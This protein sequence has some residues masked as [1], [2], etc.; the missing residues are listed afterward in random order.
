MSYG[1]VIG[2]SFLYLALLFGLASWAERR[3]AAG[4]SL[5]SNPYIYALSMAV[6]CTAW[7]YYGSIGRA[8]TTGLEFLAIYLG[9]TLMAPLWWLVLR[10]IIRIC[11]VQRITTIADFI[12]SRYGKSITLGSVVTIICV[13]GT[14]PY[15]SIQLKAIASSLFILT[16]TSGEGA[17]ITP[18]YLDVAFFVAVTLAIFTIVYG[19]RHVEATERHEGMVAAIAFESVFKL[20]IFLAAGAF[21]TYGVF[22]GFDDILQQAS[23]Q[24]GFQELMTFDSDNGFG[25]WFWLLVLSMLAILF[26]PRQFQVAVVENVNE[27]HLNKAMWLFPLYLFCINIFVLPVAL[28]GNVLFG[29]QQ[30]DVDMYVLAIPMSQGHDLLA[31]L[32]Y[33][34]GLSA[35]TSM[36]IVSTIALSVMISN[37]LLMPVLVASPV[38]RNSSSGS[39]QTLLLYSRRLSILL[40]LLLAYLYYKLVGEHYSLVEI[41]L[42][43]FV[44]VAQFAPAV[45]GGIFWKEGTRNGALA[46]IVAGFLIW[47]YTLVVPSVVGAN[48]LPVSL[49]TEGLWGLPWLKPFA[50]FGLEG[51]DYI[52]HAMF[53]S[54]FLNLGLYVGLSLVG[55]QTSKERNQA[56]VFVDIFKYSSVFES[57]IVWKG[58]AYIPDIRSLITKFL[59][60][61][62]AQE[63]LDAY[64]AQYPG[65]ASADG[66]AD[67][68]LVT[69]AETLLAGVIGSSAAHILVGSVAKAEEISIEEVLDILKESQQLISMNKELRQTSL[70]LQQATAQLQA[71]NQRLQEADELKDEFLTTV[72]HELRTP[73]TS[74][75]A[76]S[77]ILY[78]NPDLEREEQEAFLKTIVTETERLG[79]LITQVL[80]LEWFESG[81]QELQLVPVQPQQVV[82]EAVAALQ[83]LAQEKQI[84]L[85]TNL[86]PDL[87]LLA[88]NHDRLVQVLVNLISNAIK[89]CSSGV[90]R[91]VV[92]GETAPGVLRISVADN[93][94]GINLADQQQIFDKFYQ[95]RHQT[96]RKPEG[97]GLGLAISRK[98]IESHH[99]RLWVESEPGQG[100]TFIFEVPV[101]E[102]QQKQKSSFEE[103]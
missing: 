47:F 17:T 37:N 6:Y 34:G 35:A 95:A 23:Q 85:A 50:L 79:R 69:Y 62:R 16:G 93:G 42:V 76:L 43:S 54:M 89:F 70:E 90:G 28:G 11:K 59:G 73:L 18:F 9:P 78:D 5:V 32:V 4:K 56:E 31:V 60:E 52:S 1:L 26:L 14:I 67:P 84:H 88:A 44:A 64:A 24:P 100:A 72:T 3:S 96:T 41:G 30:L 75:R 61:Q 38:Q 33:L 13:M 39:F 74:I 51:M 66:K 27:Q 102:V 103:A 8:A 71:S 58:T 20:V 19:V 98:I 65:P 49:L 53:W 25:N 82:A 83:Q 45:I 10:K 2:I 22:N 68:K 81:R 80:D 29:S 63:A 86:P 77:E 7:T 87:P 57:S 48:L 91:I 97:S 101:E 40:V 55:R 36:V 94:K 46:G 21:V 12:A 92:T 99:G 15:I